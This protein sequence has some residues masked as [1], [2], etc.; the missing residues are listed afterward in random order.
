MRSCVLVLTPLALGLALQDQDAGESGESALRREVLSSQF[1]S[2]AARD[3][4]RALQ[5]LKP[6]ASHSVAQRGALE[7]SMQ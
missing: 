4:S 2:E 3:A 1:T 7:N 5:L 6:P